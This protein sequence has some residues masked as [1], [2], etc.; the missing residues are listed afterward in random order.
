M[1]KAI[2]TRVGLCLGAAF[3]ALHGHLP[4]TIV[5][6]TLIIAFEI[7]DW[8]NPCADSLRTFTHASNQQSK[9]TDTNS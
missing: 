3:L 5:A 6:C 4:G 9:T 8:G 7:Q 1:S 2:W